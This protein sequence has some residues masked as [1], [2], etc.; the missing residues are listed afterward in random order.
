MHS[1]IIERTWEI[2]WKLWAILFQPYC[3]L[4]IGFSRK[5][6]GCTFKMLSWSCICLWKFRT[7]QS[8]S[9]FVLHFIRFWNS[10][11]GRLFNSSLYMDWFDEISV[12]AY[13]IICHI[14]LSFFFLNLFCFIIKTTCWMLE[15]L[16]IILPQTESRLRY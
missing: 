13:I 4:A 6:S 7:D 14:F 11:G 15:L 12:Q 10:K 5:L 1:I 16:K 9:K 8:I 2:K 3:N